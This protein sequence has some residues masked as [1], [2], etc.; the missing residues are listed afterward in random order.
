MYVRRCQRARDDSH[1]QT[2]MF[3]NKREMTNADAVFNSSKRC[4]RFTSI[5]VQQVQQMND[6][7]M[8]D[9]NAQDHDVQQ[10][11]GMQQ[12]NEDDMPE[13]N[14]QDNEVL[15]AQQQHEV[16]GMQQN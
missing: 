3:A 14:A 9:G 2:G 11:H 8:P 1:F 13:G 4:S 10:Q 6:D 16:A 12:M 15:Q 7:V 5:E